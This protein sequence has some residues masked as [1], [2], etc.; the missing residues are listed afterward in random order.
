MGSVLSLYT[1][2]PLSPIPPPY[3][4]NISQP[5][6]PAIIRQLQKQIEVL[7]IQVGGGGAERTAVSTEVARLQ[8]FNR[9]PSKISGFVTV[10]R[11]YIRMKMR[12]V[13]VEEQIQ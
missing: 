3:H 8:M 1:S 5:N 2:L 9:T 7:I 4:Y 11:L 12:K 6:Y 10:Y 13:V